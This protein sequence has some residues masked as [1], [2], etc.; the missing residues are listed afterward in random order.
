LS[1]GGDYRTSK[2]IYGP[3]SNPRKLTQIDG[4]SSFCEFN[5]QWYHMYEY[6]CEP[7]GVRQYRQV[8]LTYLHFKDNGDMVDDEAFIQGFEGNKPGSFFI[9]MEDVPKGKYYANGVGR[10]DAQWPLIESEWFFKREGALEKKESPNGGFE[11]Q[12]IQDGDYLNFPNVRN[13]APKATITFK[14]AS[15]HKKGG[16]I[17]VHEG[18]SKGALLGICKVK[19]TGSIATYENVTCN[20]KNMTQTTD[21][22][23]VFKGGKGELMRLDNFSFKKQLSQS[24]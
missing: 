9:G 20:L 5:G 23:F 17:E 8:S 22:Y 1:C 3:Y 15:I 19:N 18:S 16:T 2:N 14:V 7:F 12:N 10:Y 13:I 4:H 11:I 24:K 6:I 21:L